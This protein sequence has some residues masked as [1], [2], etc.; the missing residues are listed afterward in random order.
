MRP[1]YLL[2]LG[3]CALATMV[4]AQAQAATPDDGA[5]V[6]LRYRFEP[7]E[8]L[9]WKVTHRNRTR[10]TV[11]GTTQ[12]AETTSVSVKVWEMKEIRPDG[13]ATFV[14]SV[15]D[16][17]MWQKMTDRAEVRYD[18]QEEG[19][20][21]RGFEHL[22]QSVGV[23]LATVTMDPQGRVLK[24]ERH[25]AKAAAKSKGLVAIPLP[26][27]PVAVGERWSKTEEIRVRPNMGS[28]RTIKARQTFELEEVET[29]VATIRV[30][31][32]ILTPIDDPAVEWQVVQHEKRGTVRFDIG[33]GRILSQHLEVDRRVV[34]FRGETSSLHYATQFDEELL[35]KI[36]AT[37]SQT[38]ALR[39]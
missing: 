39:R 27:E 28:F 36:A 8:T 23:P 26:D 33:A 17:D 20:A 4:P 7:G 31:T 14:H 2:L 1:I 22:A 5:K 29:G 25:E 6:R 3:L 18:S 13:T 24:R 21:P 30:S 9:R 32:Q 16:V 35:P 34:G 38:A 11:S 10:T 37:A 15:E 12:S 19:K